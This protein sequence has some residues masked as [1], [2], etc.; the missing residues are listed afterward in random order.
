MRQNPLGRSRE[1][2]PSGHDLKKL[3]RP[4]LLFSGSQEHLH[5]LSNLGHA[6]PNL[7]GCEV[8]PNEDLTCSEIEILEQRG[9]PI[10]HRVRTDGADITKGQNTEEVEILHRL[11]RTGKVDDEILLFN[12]TSKGQ[13]CHDQ[14]T[15]LQ[16]F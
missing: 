9:L 7:L 16:E 1:E 10:S 13:M 12:V 15:P 11:K 6:S 14:V 3:T 8:S 4:F 2:V 5:L